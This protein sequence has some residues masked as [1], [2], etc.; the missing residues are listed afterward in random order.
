MGGVVGDIH[1]VGLKY[2]LSGGYHQRSLC[3]VDTPF[4]VQYSALRAGSLDTI[5][6]AGLSTGS[7]GDP[8]QREC[9]LV[10][11][12]HSTLPMSSR[13]I[14]ESW[15]QSM[16]SSDPGSDSDVPESF[17]LTLAKNSARSWNKALK[18]AHVD[19]KRKKRERGI[20]GRAEKAQKGRK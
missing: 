7:R 16:A 4:V 13:A 11:S 6:T 1:K 3:A 17:S 18:Q 19:E 12:S 10:A 2:T 14:A 8:A 9:A 20:E 15:T 5:S